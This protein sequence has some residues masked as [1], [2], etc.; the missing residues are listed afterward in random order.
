M[1]CVLQLDRGKASPESCVMCSYGRLMT[2]L[3]LEVVVLTDCSGFSTACAHRWPSE[4]VCLHIGPQTLFS[5]LSFSFIVRSQA[6][7]R[8]FEANGVLVC[9]DIFILSAIRSCNNVDRAG[10]IGVV[11]SPFLVNHVL[12]WTLRIDRAGRLIWGIRPPMPHY[13]RGK[14]GNWRFGRWIC[15]FFPV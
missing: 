8:G 6:L 13:V 11:F 12:R 14:E 10:F 4:L 7:R 2:S 15:L 9:F 1:F 3:V 5:A